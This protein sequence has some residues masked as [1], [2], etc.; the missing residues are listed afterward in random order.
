M[1]IK[2]SIIFLLFNL[3]SVFSQHESI[4]KEYSKQV[5]TIDSLK[6]VIK[7]EKENSKVQFESLIKKQD[8]IK[9]LK[10]TL[11]KLEEF[12]KEKKKVDALIQQKNDSII[13]FI[14]QKAE[15]SQ[16]IVNERITYEQETLDEKEKAKSEI[17]SKIINT[18]KNKNFEDLI[19]SSNKL[20]IQRDL[21][22]IGDNNEVKQILIDLNKYYE[23]KSL[24]EKPFDG[25]QNKI[26]QTELNKIN[27][28]SASLD[29][30]KEHIDNYQLIDK[31]IKECITNI[32][33]LDKKE[34]VSG[35]GE[36]IKKLKLN[37][38]LTEIS[39]YI[40]NYDF[41][42]TEYP[43]LS[44]ILS[45]VIKIKFPNPDQ[46]ISNLLKQ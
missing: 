30:L 22:R 41:N 15:L 10:S 38:I 21:Q 25:Q 12:K 43:Y 16:K 2:I 11:S 37:K 3:F 31:G 34:T 40:F 44:N 26:R 39:K 17:F 28:Q 9:K 27:R 5:I 32:N 18:Y 8:T 19:L 45:Q 23:V 36:E 4:L 6:K 1:K 33:S 35:M 7:T 42:F 29:K 24:L 14:K 46:D 20:S 13:I